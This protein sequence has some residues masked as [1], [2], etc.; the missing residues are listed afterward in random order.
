MKKLYNCNATCDERSLVSYKT[1]IV[2]RDNACGFIA[3]WYYPSAT[4]KSHKG[5]AYVVT[6]KRTG[7]LYATVRDNK[8]TIFSDAHKRSVTR[9]IKRCMQ[10]DYLEV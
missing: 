7:E 2:W 10:Y 3:I 1:R 5:Y 9:F 4:S 6:D 8:I